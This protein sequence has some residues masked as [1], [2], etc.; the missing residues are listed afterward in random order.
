MVYSIFSSFL[1]INMITT[2]YWETKDRTLI[3]IMD[4]SDTH[5]VNCIRLINKSIKENNPWRKDAL[6][7]LRNELKRRNLIRRENGDPI[8][9]YKF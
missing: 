3:N 9:I 6:P 7:Y 2:V 8:I 5:I 1:L 4:M